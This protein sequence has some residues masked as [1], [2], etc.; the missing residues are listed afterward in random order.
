MVYAL[1]KFV[2]IPSVS[3]SAAHRED[4][5]Q[6]AIWLR[7]CLTQLGAEASLVG[8]FHGSLK[9]SL[10]AL[11][12]I[13]THRRWHQ[14]VGPRDFPWH[15]NQA[16]SAAD[17]VLWVCLAR[18]SCVA[19]ADLCFSHYDVIAASARG[20]SSDPFSLT[21]RNGYL[22]GR[23]AT[24]NKGP[25]M[26]VACAAADLLSRRALE[27]DLIFVIEGEEEAGSGGF[28]EAVRK[29]KVRMIWPGRCLAFSGR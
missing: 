17:I 15:P 19:S 20:W 8:K 9:L 21:G 23:G 1:S 22:Y 2:S 24:D 27:L 11:A 26:A 18:S 25:I 12:L 10:T 28:K 3:N 7:K 5:R 6:A 14:P 13:A 4:C 16:Q 29:H